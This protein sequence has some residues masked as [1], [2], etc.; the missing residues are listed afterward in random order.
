M[1]LPAAPVPPKWPYVV[2][3]CATT[4]VAV[5]AVVAIVLVRPDKDNTSLI[6]VIVG[7]VAPTI[8]AILA[9]I[10]GSESADA[11]KE[12]R[13]VVDGRLTQLLE[14]TARAEHL[15]GQHAGEAR[16]EQKNA[17]TAEAAAKTVEAATKTAQVAVKVAEAAAAAPPI[18]GPKEEAKDG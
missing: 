7:M 18:N 3:A 6:T 10:K 11:V 8:A 9:L 4:F 12:L 15:A 2:A 14:Q 17:A 5:A 13:V 16:A 1:T